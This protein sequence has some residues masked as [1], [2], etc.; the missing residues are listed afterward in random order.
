M[1]KQLLESDA[2]TFAT[3]W[4]IFCFPSNI[5]YFFVMSNLFLLLFSYALGIKDQEAILLLSVCL[6]VC[7]FVK[8][9]TLQVQSTVMP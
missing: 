3:G 2:E 6:S 4:C 8:L 7:L 9:Q 1:I 5:I